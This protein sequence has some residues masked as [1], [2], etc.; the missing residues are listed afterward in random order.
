LIFLVLASGSAEAQVRRL[1]ILGAQP[2]PLIDEFYNELKRLGWRE[3]EN[4]KTDYRWTRTENSQAGPM[5]VDLVKQQPEVI[6]APANPHY[7]AAR[8]A[9]SSIPIVFCTHGDPVSSGHARSLAR[10]GGNMTGISVLVVDLLVKDL[11]LLTEAIPQLRSVAVLR[12]SVSRQPYDAVLAP[13]AKRLD[14]EVSIIEAENDSDYVTAFTQMERDK[15]GAVIVSPNPIFY[16]A[17]DRLAALAL[18]HRIPA[19]MGFKEGAIAGSLLAYAAD[20]KEAYRGCARYVDGILRGE[21]PANMPIEQASR[22]DLVVNLRTAKTL[23]LE[24]P[25]SIMGRADEVIE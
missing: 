23:G 20:L 3:G 22:Y 16:F 19:I 4:L 13:A 12:Q 6:L 7:S 10:P 9:T 21:N 5:A 11:E 2:N 24:M 17:R 15:I 18:K 1:G 8:S 14:V 25:S